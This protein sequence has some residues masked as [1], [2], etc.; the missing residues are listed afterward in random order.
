MYYS[1]KISIIFLLMLV[2]IS[3]KKGKFKTND[4]DFQKIY[5]K[6]LKWKNKSQVSWDSEVHSYTFTLSENKT[7]K[8]IG[9]QSYSSLQSTDYIIEIINA[10]DSTVVY[11]GGHQ[12]SSSDISYVNPNYAV[13][14]QSGV[15]YTITRIQSNW[16]QYITETIGHG[17][18]TEDSDYP[19]SH[20]ILTITGTNRYDFGD[21]EMDP[22][23]KNDMLP[24]I[25][26]VF[27]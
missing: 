14:L 25:D 21:T 6:Q 20:G 17:V 24:R 3:C 15:T 12:F 9:Y 2:L 16:V 4:S 18:K 19:M 23:S 1:K 10:S 13:Q 11:S 7:L 22:Y 5:N 8:S 26:L 27:E